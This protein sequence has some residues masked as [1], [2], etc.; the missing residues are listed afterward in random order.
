MMRN[1]RLLVAYDGTDFLGWQRQPHGNTV[2]GTLEEAAGKVIGHNVKLIGSGRTDAGVHALGQVANFNT[3]NVIPCGALAK[4]L[5]DVLPPAIRIRDVDE[6]DFAFH[7]RHSARAKTYVYRILQSPVALPFI[8]RY[9]YHYPY[10]LD[11]ERMAKAAF[12]FEGERD[13]TSFVASTDAAG[14]KENGGAVRT[15]YASRIIPR[16]RSSMLVYRVRGSGFLRYMVRNI[17]GTL[18][19]AGRGRLQPEEVIRILKARDRRRAGPTAPAQGL[20]LIS[21]EYETV[22]R[23]APAGDGR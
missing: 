5:N 14:E 15:I 4:A 16:P 19:E 2:Q 6:V 13:F 8:N 23:P 3:A 9:V 17:V 22:A 18:I 12:I 20:C 10:A 21:V 11:A 1:L 7:S